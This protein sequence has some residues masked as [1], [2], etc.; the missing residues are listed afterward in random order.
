MLLPFATF[1]LDRLSRKPERLR[2]P[3][4]VVCTEN[5]IRVDGRENRLA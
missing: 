3:A 5:M 4:R 2:P 1:F